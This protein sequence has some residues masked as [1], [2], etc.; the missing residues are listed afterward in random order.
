MACRAATTRELVLRR[1]QE[2]AMAAP[3]SP[4]AP[5]LITGGSSGIGL[6]MARMLVK[7]GR[8]VAIMG[9]DARKL[10]D[11]EAELRAVSGAPV[12]TYCG[13]VG[14]YRD[15]RQ[16]VDATLDAFGQLGLAIANAGIAKP[17][18]FAQQPLADHINQMQTN[19]FGSLHLAEASVAA[20][21]NEGGGSSLSPRERH[22]SACTDIRPMLR[23]NMPFGA[24]PRSCVWNSPS[25][26]S[27]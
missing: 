1:L 21:A 7:A 6:A 5:A 17:G 23:R 25:V 3:L 2:T 9:R 24:S 4:K 22:S 15:V 13:D 12:L 10:R 14:Q 16:A 19:Y 20:L 8:P 11:A 26:G 27:R 18:H